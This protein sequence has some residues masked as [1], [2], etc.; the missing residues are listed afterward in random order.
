MR[1]LVLSITNDIFRLI[2]CNF[3]G[4]T[5]SLTLNHYLD[6]CSL[7]SIACKF[8]VVLFY[9]FNDLCCSFFT[10]RPFLNCI[11]S[12][13]SNLTHNSGCILQD[14]SYCW[15]KFILFATIFT[16]ISYSSL[17]VSL[18]RYWRCS[19]VWFLMDI[20][21]HISWMTVLPWNFSPQAL[22]YC[23]PGNFRS[24]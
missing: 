17:I 16:F 12:P 1:G 9:F 14:K 24:M 19:C 3:R 10:A 18:L 5:N 8:D 2:F 23:M 7:V 6:G 15:I 4:V 21:L 11:R 22:K 20:N 13:T